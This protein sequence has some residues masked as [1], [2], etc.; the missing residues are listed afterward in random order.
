M[1]SVVAPGPASA[2]LLPGTRPGLTVVPRR[3]PAG[4]AG[5]MAAQA[6]VRHA[7]R[8]AL[9]EFLDYSGF[10]EL[11]TPP[12]ATLATVL[13]RTCWP[14][15]DGGVAGWLDGAEAP[16]LIDLL[17]RGL[18]AALHG[19]LARAYDDFAR[20]GVDRDRLKYVQL[21]LARR[22]AAPDA[23]IAE[24]ILLLQGAPDAGGPC[25]TA[26][27]R[28]DARVLLPRAGCVADATSGGAFRFDLAALLAFLCWT[29]VAA[30]ARPAAGGALTLAEREPAGS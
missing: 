6:R 17:E 28:R 30:L 9:Q 15:P 5:R 2:R 7:L 13:G 18:T 25:G 26:T 29:E 19:T 3:A 24:P 10:V 8:R 4:S 27:S 22:C 12:D 11:D 1:I 16:A 21:P 14:T 20:L 23:P